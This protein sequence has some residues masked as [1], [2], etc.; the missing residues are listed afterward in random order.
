[1]ARYDKYDP[2]SGGFRAKLNADLTLDGNG[3]FGP[4]AVSLNTSGRVVVGT[5]GQ[6]G[7]VGIL[8]KNAAKQAVTRWG[9]STSG[10]PNAAAP[11]G[12][13]AGDVVDIMTNGEIVEV[14]GFTA[15]QPV[16]AHADGSLDAVAT[17]GTKVGYIV[18]VVN[19]RGR[20]VVRTAA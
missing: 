15:G 19:G 6:S 18:E 17:A 14:T 8:V 4:R 11:I 5:A 2:I 1:M 9:L 16:Y 10:T 12:A 3:E 13:L 20:M 7:L